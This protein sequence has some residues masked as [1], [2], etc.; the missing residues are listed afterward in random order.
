MQVFRAVRLS[1]VL[2]RCL[3]AVN[4]LRSPAEADFYLVFDRSRSCEG[5][6]FE[7]REQPSIGFEDIVR[8]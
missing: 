3:A 7:L 8:R 6:S 4:G 5:V 2:A 1:L